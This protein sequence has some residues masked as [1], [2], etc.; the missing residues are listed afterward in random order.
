MCAR[1][2]EFLTTVLSPGLPG[3][4]PDRAFFKPA[5]QVIS[6]ERF[7]TMNPR[8]AF[9]LA[10]AVFL[11]G[12]C[13]T[14]GTDFPD[15]YASK[16]VIGKTTRADI[17]K[18]LGRPFRTGLDSGDPTASYVYYHLGLFSEPVT[19]DLTVRYSNGGVVKSYTF[20]ANVKDP[21]AEKVDYNAR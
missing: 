13:A 21:D 20:N 6:S 3:C 10:V 5:V 7:F 4:N 17:E 18:H 8:I 11:L 14:V 16:I 9:A 15:Q 19:K 1:F 12:A 2:A